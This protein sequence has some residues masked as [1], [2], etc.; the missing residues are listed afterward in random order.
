MP[1][2]KCDRKRDQA[3]C[4]ALFDPP[5]PKRPDGSP[6]PD[7]VDWHTLAPPAV[8]CPCKFTDAVDEAPGKYLLSFV[9]IAKDSSF[10]QDRYTVHEARWTAL[11]E[12]A[13]NGDDEQVAWLLDHG[14]HARA[15]SPN[16]GDPVTAALSGGRRDP[17]I[18]RRLFEAGA[19]PAVVSMAAVRDAELARWLANQ[20]VS[21]RTLEMTAPT[22][23]W[24]DEA[25]DW[26]LTAGPDLATTIGPT[27][28]PFDAKAREDR[29]RRLVDAGLAL[30][31][32][33]RDA[34]GKTVLHTYACAD[35]M[36]AAWL[37]EHGADPDR[38]Q[39][40]FESA[41]DEAEQCGAEL[42]RKP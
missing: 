32:P 21:T 30:D 7:W 38:K 36:F 42:P 29:V 27:D 23:E 22:W 1:A 9:P 26:A 10:V 5:Y 6:N 14:A 15:P 16:G 4:D 37:I 12:A 35:P 39:A 31:G 33:T 19:D 11:F 25:F 17:K 13:R 18:A 3:F 41:R 40:P 2:V 8:D 20:G 24:P 28:A 34:F